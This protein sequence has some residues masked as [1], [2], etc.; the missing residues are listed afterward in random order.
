MF[1]KQDLIARGKTYEAAGNIL[2][3]HKKKQSYY[4]KGLGT[5]MRRSNM[6]RTACD[7]TDT[8]EEPDQ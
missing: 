8:R 1:S 7:T 5:L 4:R 2:L 6:Q 3:L